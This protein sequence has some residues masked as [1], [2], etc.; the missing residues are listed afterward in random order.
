MGNIGTNDRG[1]V[2]KIVNANSESH[3]AVFDWFHEQ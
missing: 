1:S 3:L 2:L